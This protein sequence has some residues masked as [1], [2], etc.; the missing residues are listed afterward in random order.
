MDHC[1][2]ILP[3]I[4]EIHIPTLTHKEPIVLLT[5]SMEAL[6]AKSAKLQSV[7]STLNGEED[8][9]QDFFWAHFFSELHAWN[10]K[11][12]QPEVSS[13]W[14]DHF[15]QSGVYFEKRL[16]ANGWSLRYLGQNIGP[17]EECER[18]LRNAFQLKII[19]HIAPGPFLHH[20]TSLF[21][22]NQGCSKI[23]TRNWNMLRFWILT[24]AD[25][26]FHTCIFIMSQC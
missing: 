11:K 13:Y 23:S 2:M 1:W 5:K 10:Y 22:N 17:V 16:W 19:N 26:D 14:I 7:A 12:C 18:T 20:P 4:P 6:L 21:H 24:P 15:A 25:S 8:E 3:Q 9:R